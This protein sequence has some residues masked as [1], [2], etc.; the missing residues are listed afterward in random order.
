MAVPEPESEPAKPSTNGRGSAAPYG[1]GQPNGVLPGDHR[2]ADDV[3]A[4]IVALWTEYGKER[5]QPLRGIR[6]RSCTTPRW[7]SMSPAA[8]APACPR[9]STSA[10]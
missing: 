7:S 2:T 10:T 3:E 6:D 4:G 5:D 1:I 9:T 8:S